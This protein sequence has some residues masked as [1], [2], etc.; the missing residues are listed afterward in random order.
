[1]KADEKKWDM[2]FLKEYP[3]MPF[4]SLMN[5]FGNIN[6]GKGMDYKDFEKSAKD[7]FSLAKSFVKEQYEECSDIKAQDNDKEKQ[8][9]FGVEEAN[10]FEKI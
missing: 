3:F 7:I 9:A 4:G 5:A 8:L 2:K 10:P 1:M 6:Q